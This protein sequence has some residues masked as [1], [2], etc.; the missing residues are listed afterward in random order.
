MVVFILCNLYANEGVD[1]ITVV[2]GDKKLLEENK[3]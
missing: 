1:L 2:K 3:N